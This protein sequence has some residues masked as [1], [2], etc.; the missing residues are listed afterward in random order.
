[1]LKIMN[2]KMVADEEGNEVRA[3]DL[4]SL[5]FKIDEVFKYSYNNL[6][7]EYPYRV[8]LLEKSEAIKGVKE[9]GITWVRKGERFAEVYNWLKEMLED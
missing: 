5:L 6:S 1:M 2:V 7:H 4:V 9:L 8:S 3:D